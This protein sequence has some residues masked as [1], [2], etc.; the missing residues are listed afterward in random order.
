VLGVSL[1]GPRL[2]RQGQFQCKLT[3]RCIPHGWICDGDSD[4]G[5]TSRMV[6]DMSDEDV[7]LCE[8]DI[9]NIGTGHLPNTNVNNY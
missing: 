8:S 7:Q 1:S 3:H 4:C 2:C 5:V 9:H 6:P